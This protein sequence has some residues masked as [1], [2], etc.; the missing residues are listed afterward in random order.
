MKEYVISWPSFPATSVG[1]AVIVR[2]SERM[3]RQMRSNGPISL[4][5][6]GLSDEVAQGA[7][8]GGGVTNSPWGADHFSRRQF[9]RHLDYALTQHQLNV[10]ELTHAYPL[11]GPH[12]P[13]TVEIPAQVYS[14]LNGGISRLGDGPISSPFYD[15]STSKKLSTK[16]KYTPGNFPSSLTM[17]FHN[18]LLS[19]NIY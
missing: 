4:S 15:M 11:F 12:F 7:A 18:W 14:F 10:H 2:A 13:Y 9:Y 1:S 3:E 17:S 16:I 8:Q 6:P 19:A 5:I